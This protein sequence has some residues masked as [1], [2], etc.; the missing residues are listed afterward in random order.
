MPE[1]KRYCGNKSI[2]KLLGGLERT[3]Y[4]DTY[5]IRFLMPYSEG[6]KLLH[7]SLSV[8][9][10]PYS[11]DIILISEADLT[12]IPTTGVGENVKLTRQNYGE[13][14]IKCVRKINVWDSTETTNW[15]E[16]AFTETAMEEICEIIEHWIFKAIK[17]GSYYEDILTIKD[18]LFKA[19]TR[20]IV[21][22]MVCS[23]AIVNDIDASIEE[24]QEKY[25]KGTTSI[26]KELISEIN[27][28]IIDL[29]KSLALLVPKKL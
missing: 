17:T 1:D 10:A 6:N 16:I 2:C 18:S 21:L 15:E 11:K 20:D 7:I 12:M 27:S 9:K 23:S 8:I 29:K 24:L 5:D 13:E 3:E 26:F 28:D 19:C 4:G 25:R 22:K 14:C